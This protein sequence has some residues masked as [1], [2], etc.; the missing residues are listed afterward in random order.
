LRRLFPP[1]NAAE[2]DPQ[3]AYG[4]LGLPR[5]DADRPYV[6]MNMVS[7]VDGKSALG[8]TAAGIGSKTD[9]AMMRQIRAGVDA[10]MFGAGTL[11]AELV[12]PRVDVPG[13]QTRIARGQPAQ[14]VAVAVSGSL[15][16]DPAHRFLVN[17]RA[18]T[19]ILTTAAAP[20]DRRARL[21]P[22]ATI[23]SCGAG[24][25][26]LAT[27]LRRLRA[28]FGV[29]WLLSE[30]GPTLNQALLDA[31]LIDEVFWTI[32]PKLA[33]G[34]GRNLIDGPLPTE[35]VKARLELRSL[36]EQDGELFA[37]YRLLRHDGSASKV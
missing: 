22:Y 25:V 13:V 9:W 36:L 8:Q 29:R 33:G 31:G 19:V 15:D 18:G 26:D 3:S 37:R 6:L 23:L 12:D 27:A 21:A 2:T 14:P 34:R 32:A 4:D 7:T 28:E 35:R 11:R 1:D 20:A 16:L 17:G 24:T 10:I 5:M 30:G